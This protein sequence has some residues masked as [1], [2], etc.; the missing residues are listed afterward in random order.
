MVKV[1]YVTEKAK[2]RSLTMHNASVWVG[3]FYIYIYIYIFD[4]TFVVSRPITEGY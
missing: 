3:K 2:T 1:G 4:M